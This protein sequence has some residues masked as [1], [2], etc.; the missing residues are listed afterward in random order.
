MSKQ[1]SKKNF[2]VPEIIE[3]F[4]SNPE[5]AYDKLVSSGHY[6]HSN[7]ASKF[8]DQYLRLDLEKLGSSFPNATYIFNDVVWLKVFYDL[9]EFYKAEKSKC[10][11]QIRQLNPSQA[12]LI[13][14]IFLCLELGELNPYSS[15]FPTYSEESL[16][17]VKVSL[18]ELVPL[19]T[20]ENQSSYSTKLFQIANDLIRIQLDIKLLGDFIDAYVWADFV[21]SQ[22]ENGKGFLLSLPVGFKKKDN[23]FIL[24][25]L[26]TAIKR[27]FNRQ[28]SGPTVSEEDHF[29]KNDVKWKT[30]EGLATVFITGATVTS[31]PAGTTSIEVD[32]NYFENFTSEDPQKRLEAQNKI[33]LDMM[34]QNFHYRYRSALEEIYQPNDNIDIHAL[35]LELKPKNFIS[36]YHIISVM[37]CLTARADGFRYVSELPQSWSIRSIKNEILQYLDQHKPELTIEEKHT[38]CDWDVIKN[39]SEINIHFGGKTFLFVT[40]ETLLS[41]CVKIE[42]LKELTRQQLKLIIDLLSGLKTPLPFNPLY[43]VGDQYYFSYAACTKFNLSR[44]L[45]DH[46]ISERL[47]SPMRKP[48]EERK[49]VSERS[50]KRA[51]SFA[52]L[53]SELFKTLTPYTAANIDYGGSKSNS[54]FGELHGDIDT[55]A[56]FEK[57]NI[58]IS[59]QIKLSNVSP[60]N[61]KRKNE[62]I[63]QRIDNSA[64]SQT[65]KDMK[66][67]E[68]ESGLKHVS[69]ELGIEEGKQIVNPRIYALIVTDNFFADHVAFDFNEQGDS[70]RCISYFELK[71][72]ILNQKVHDKQRDW[73]ID[74]NGNAAADLIEA[75][76]TD[77]FWDFIDAAAET[78][79]FQKTLSSINDEYKIEMKI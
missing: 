40:E 32:E 23:P 12:D 77:L 63:R 20:S 71:H 43:K 54:E 22:K 4:Q 11:A 64:L 58:L 66:L 10:L 56:Y 65:V 24:E 29:K 17:A 9:G 46:Y 34:E 76:E 27:E 47:F 55:L 15:N 28:Q 60:K 13:K 19:L 38:I 70:V 72:L 51:D 61:E 1:S 48:E 26:K 68:I 49:Q 6:F 33:M 53:T 16:E 30:H 69:K 25:Q 39:F 3:L 59:I 18:K 36:L 35:H 5:E 78:F 41:W 14:S 45:Y 50:T 42:E 37:C 21:M 31:Q 79:E 44:A 57:E 73:L 75:I 52:N 74:K 8:W 62:W 2:S 67:L 7:L